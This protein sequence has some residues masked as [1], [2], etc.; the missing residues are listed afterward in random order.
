[1]WFSRYCSF[2]HA[3][4]IDHEKVIHNGLLLPVRDLYCLMDASLLISDNEI[5]NCMF[6][7]LISPTLFFQ[8]YESFQRIS[9]W[10]CG[11]FICFVFCFVF[12]SYLKDCCYPLYVSFVIALGGF[13]IPLAFRLEAWGLLPFLSS[14]RCR[15]GSV[16]GSQRCSTALHSFF[17]CH[18]FLIVETS[19]FPNF[20]GGFSFG[21]R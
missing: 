17:P 7:S 16:F 6:L 21:D 3:A 8:Y 9:Y 4:Q 13:P 18:S 1:M 15:E 14:A 19:V 5:M 11:D 10:L 2:H 20:R 12:P